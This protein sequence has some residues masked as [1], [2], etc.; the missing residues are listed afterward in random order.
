ME[1]L[2][3]T[4]SL[5]VGTLYAC[6]Q[7]IQ[8]RGIP[9]HGVVHERLRTAWPCERPQPRL[10]ARRDRVLRNASTGDGSRGSRRERR[11]GRPATR[12]NKR[13]GSTGSRDRPGG[14]L[15]RQ[16]TLA[17]WQPSCWA[18]GRTDLCQQCEKEGLAGHLFLLP[19]SR[20]SPGLPFLA[21]TFLHPLTILPQLSAEHSSASPT[22]SPLV[23]ASNWIPEI[24]T[25]PSLPSIQ[26]PRCPRTPLL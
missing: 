13:E 21:P 8:H 24:S 15:C 25:S 10:G 20:P 16:R 6:K 9:P 18:K 14:P 17:A 3:E 1:T 26:L 22:L 4:Q 12:I 2:H 19:T 23:Q 5:Q 7:R 11:S